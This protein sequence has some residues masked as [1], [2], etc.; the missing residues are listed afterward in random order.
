MDKLT[1]TRLLRMAEISQLLGCSTR[2]EIMHHLANG[3]EVAVGALAEKMGAGISGVSSHLAKLRAGGLVSV[4]QDKQTR[5]Y[6][7]VEE[8][9]EELNGLLAALVG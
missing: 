1:Y 9:L 4:R 7:R 3:G 2:A 5:Y 8:T 6:S